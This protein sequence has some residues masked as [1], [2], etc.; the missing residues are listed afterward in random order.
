MYVKSLDFLKKA[1]GITSLCTIESEYVQLDLH[2]F[3]W[4]LHNLLGN[5]V[6]TG[7][8]GHMELKF[9]Y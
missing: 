4:L 5:L 1:K 2:I 6:Q 9:I 7:R 8:E 3:T